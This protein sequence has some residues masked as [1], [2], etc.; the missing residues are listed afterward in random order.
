MCSQGVRN[1]L[2]RGVRKNLEVKCSWL[3]GEKDLRK[4]RTMDYSGKKKH[5]E[6]SMFGEIEKK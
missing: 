5:S 4:V 1:R 6:K 3:K 2:K